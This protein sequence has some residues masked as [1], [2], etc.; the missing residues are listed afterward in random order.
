M[1]KNKSF[2]NSLAKVA[3]ITLAILL[4]PFTANFLTNE[5]SWS[6]SDFIIAGVALFGTG[7]GYAFI[8]SKSQNIIFRVATAL[9]L[10][11]GLLLFWANGAVGLIGSE[12]NDI[13]LMYYA[14][15]LIFLIGVLISRFK[16]P[17]MAVALA[18]TAVVQAS[19]IVIAL[20]MDAHHL[21]YSSISEIIMVNLFFVTLFAVS[22][23]LFWQIVH[24]SEIEEP[25]S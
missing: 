12:N 7:A 20:L 2:Q 3:A 19:T 4:I 18:V 15:F 22:A 6:T 23:G 17:K 14:V 10:L 9:A 11:S 5:V 16:A 25:N 21:P 8:S 1:T 24:K 13:N